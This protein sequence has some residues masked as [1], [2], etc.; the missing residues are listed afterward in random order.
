ME[1]GEMERGEMERGKSHHHCREK[2]T[3]MIYV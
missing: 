2:D 1:R 3:S